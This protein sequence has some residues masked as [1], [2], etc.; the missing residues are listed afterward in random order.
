MI[1]VKVTCDTGKTWNTGI[2]ADLEGARKY[3][4]GQCFVDEDFETGK[5]T[6]NVAVNVEQIA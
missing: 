6:R 3:F 1:N 4:I 2:N 5:E